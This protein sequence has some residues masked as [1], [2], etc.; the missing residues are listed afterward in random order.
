MTAE[1]TTARD[2]LSPRDLQRVLRETFIDRVDHCAESPSTNSR[3][4]ELAAAAPGDGQS[5]LVIADRQTAGRGRGENTWWSADGALTFSVL[6]QTLQFAVPVSRWPQ[7][8]LT[9][10]L[11]ICEAI[12][13]ICPQLTT[14]IKWPNDVYLGGRKVAG[15]LVEGADVNRGRLIVGIGLNVNN[16]MTHAPA[17]LRDKA[18]A[19]C[20]VVGVRVSPIEL[21]VAIL[22]H[23]AARFEWLSGGTSELREVWSRRCLLTGRQVEIELPTRRIVGHC[24]GIDSEGALVVNT[25]CGGSERCLSGCVVEFY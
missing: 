18:T 21:L 24:A 7:L 19:L 8:S 15:I 13:S 14:T 1:S 12:E 5:I 17:E 11:A 6:I 23:L 2:H 25:I 22:N 10:G 4:L 3:A 16:S 9:T 20:D